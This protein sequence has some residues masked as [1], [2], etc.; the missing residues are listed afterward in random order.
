MNNKVYAQNRKANFEYFLI[1]RFE[2][3]LELTGPEVKAIRSGGA[4]LVGAY[5]FINKT[6]ECF[7]SGLKLRKPKTVSSTESLAFDT[8]RVK[9]LLLKKREAIKL[10]EKLKEKGLTIVP[11]FIYQNKRGFIKLEIALAK[12]KNLY[13]KRK[14]I[15][16]RDVKRQERKESKYTN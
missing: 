10:N 7:V 2:A 3:G 8:E 1:E 9:R 4:E 14:T 6:L 16:E 13:D 5:V 11:T 12:G 15:K